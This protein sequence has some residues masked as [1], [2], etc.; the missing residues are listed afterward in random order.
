MIQYLKRTWKNKVVALCL[1]QL[2]YMTIGIDNDVTAFVFILLF[3]VPLFFAK[4]NID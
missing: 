2:G 3:A 4:N 1:M